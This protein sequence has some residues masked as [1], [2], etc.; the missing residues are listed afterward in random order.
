MTVQILEDRDALARAVAHR[1]TERIDELRRSTGRRPRLVLTGGTIANEVLA[2]LVGP[3]SLWRD[4]DYY[5]GDE[6]Y[7]PSDDDDRNEKQARE[8]FLTRFEIPEDRIHPMPAAGEFASKDDAADAYAAQLPES[9]DL[10]LLGV[11]PDAHVAS[12]FPGFPQLDEKERRVVPVDDSPK[13]PPE[14]L[15]L[16]YP[17]LNSAT[18]VWFVVAGED[19]APA[20]A[21]ALS[22]A[23]VDEAPAAG[24]RGV[25]ETLWLLDTDSASRL[26]R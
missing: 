25:E 6:R 5:W 17:M 10:V 7:V 1:L 2:Q 24:V 26:P 21:A 23:P 15:S 8:A 18:A 13:P 20:V 19:K 9:F 3:V 14:R 4:V 12:L 11:G 22:G 16:T